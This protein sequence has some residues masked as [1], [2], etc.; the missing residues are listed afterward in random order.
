M[1]VTKV[2]G[3]IL[4]QEGE[5]GKDHVIAYASYSLNPSEKNYPVHKLKFLALKW[6]VTDQFHE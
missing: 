4:Y 2:W 6:A 1:L 3:A 5:D